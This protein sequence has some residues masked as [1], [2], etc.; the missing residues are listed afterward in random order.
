MMAPVK[1][2]SC[3]S[4]NDFYKLGSIYAH[5]HDPYGDLGEQSNQQWKIQLAWHEYLENERQHIK[6]FECQIYINS[7]GGESVTKPE[8]SPP[9]NNFNEYPEKNE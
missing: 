2:L 7:C 3:F 6:W 8:K 1:N 4:H 5:Q 9:A